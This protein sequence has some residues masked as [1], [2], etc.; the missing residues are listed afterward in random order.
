MYVSNGARWTSVLQRY[1]VLVNGSFP[2][3]QFSCHARPKERKLPTT[4]C[5]APS[6]ALLLQ[7]IGHLL[8][9]VDTAYHWLSKQR[10]HYPA[11]ADIWCFGTVNLLKSEQVCAAGPVKSKSGGGIFHP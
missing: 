3:V 2:E 4:P 10:K 8:N 6:A 5:T 1:R 7:K 9:H 11:Q